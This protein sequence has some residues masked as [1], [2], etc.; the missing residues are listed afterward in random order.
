MSQVFADKLD[1]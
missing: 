1:F